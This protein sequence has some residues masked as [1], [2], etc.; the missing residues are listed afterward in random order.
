VEGSPHREKAPR[1]V[2]AS[3]ARPTFVGFESLKRDDQIRECGCG[4]EVDKHRT[5]RDVVKRHSVK[6]PLVGVFCLVCEK[7]CSAIELLAAFFDEAEGN[8]T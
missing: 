3:I 1:A 4:H 6:R 7:W 5:V 8:P 2:T